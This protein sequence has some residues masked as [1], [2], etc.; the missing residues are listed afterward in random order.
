M[1]RRLA[2]GSP[3]ERPS[4]TLPLQSAGLLCALIFLINSIF[5][6]LVINYL[7][8]SQYFLIALLLAVL[9]LWAFLEVALIG[10]RAIMPPLRIL[11][12][13]LASQIV[14]ILIRHSGDFSSRSAALSSAAIP[15]LSPQFGLAIVF[16]PIY[17]LLFLAISRC[18]I[19]AFSYAERR[20]A[21]QLLRQMTILKQT[22]AE[23]Q[24][25]ELRYRLIADNVDDV[26]WT[27]DSQGRF[28]FISPSLKTLLGYGPEQWIG[29]PLKSLLDPASSF[30]LESALKQWLKQRQPVDA[31]LPSH[32]AELEH[33]HRD[34]SL[35]WTEITMAPLRQEDGQL[36]GFVGVT[37][38]IHIRKLYER[39]LS[40][41]RE[42]AE[43]TN[44]A[45]ISA[46][47]LLHGRATTDGLTGLLN[48]RH[49]EDIL[50]A[51]M[52]TS[53]EYE[54]NLSL[55]V[56]DIDNFKDVNDKSGHTLGDRIL[57][58][59]SNLISASLRKS[60]RLARWGGDEFIMMMPRVQADEALQVANRLCES[61][62][63]HTFPGGR[64]VTLSIGVAERRPHESLD[65]WFDRADAALYAVK[66]AGRNAARHSA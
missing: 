22:K 21:K 52:K 43:E 51:Q 32:R 46:N 45:L 58:D 7:Y 28:T 19:D 30:S 6:V 25:S 4:I 31:A 54:E 64:V 48:R 12:L 40:E 56:I 5:E 66:K 34:G 20:R 63:C 35:L 55:R 13:L 37:R 57:I 16:L 18:L 3:G 24:A 23:L 47:A 11:K 33:V 44:S 10:R 8:G 29:K 38:D 36:M 27:L 41:A 26:I 59:V 1:P 60:D 61:V 62:A 39:N 2:D 15:A 49:F 65:Q 50:R 42:A 9:S 53:T 17:L 14:L